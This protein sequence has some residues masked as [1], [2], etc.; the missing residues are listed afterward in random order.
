RLHTLNQVIALTVIA[1]LFAPM[2]A[3]TIGCAIDAAIG[4]HV[5][6][7]AW[8]LWWIGDATGV[9]IALPLVLVFVQIWHGESALLRQHALEAA[10]LLLALFG[11]AALAVEANLPFYIMMPPLLWAAVRF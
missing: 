4:K 10:G 1:V 11:L 8:P 6:T 2:I 5:F 3:A 9:L 7:T